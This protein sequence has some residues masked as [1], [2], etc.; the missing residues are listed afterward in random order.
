M[1][2]IFPFS[3]T[4]FERWIY[5]QVALLEKM[6][7]KALWRGTNRIL[8]ISVSKLSFPLSQP[9]TPSST[10]RC[11]VLSL[12]HTKPSGVQ[13]L[14]KTTKSTKTQIS[15]F[16]PQKAQKPKN[17]IKKHPQMPPFLNIHISLWSEYYCNKHE[18]LTQHRIWRERTQ[19]NLSGDCNRILTQSH[20]TKITFWITIDIK[21]VTL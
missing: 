11:T 14:I 19:E 8:I 4:I 20:V 17:P 3:N 10:N 15:A 7:Q 2:L 5:L 9:P 13:C 6:F 1:F 21:W 12:V 18:H 16:E